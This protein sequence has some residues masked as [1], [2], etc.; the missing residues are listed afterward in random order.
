MWRFVRC[1]MPTWIWLLK[2][3]KRW[4]EFGPHDVQRYEQ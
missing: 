2:V 1:G 4:Q 3:G